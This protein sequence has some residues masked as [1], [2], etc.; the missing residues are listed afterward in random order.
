MITKKEMQELAD[1]VYHKLK[2]DMVA[3]AKE[4]VKPE[5]E[6][7]LSAKEVGKIIGWSQGHVYRRKDD[8]GCYVRSKNRLLF[9]KSQVHRAIQEGRLQ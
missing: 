6:E 7:Y 9:I 1:M 5:T 4:I 8:L 2:N 3:A